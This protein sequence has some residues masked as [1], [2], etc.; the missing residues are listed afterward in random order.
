MSGGNWAALGV[1]AGLLALLALLLLLLCIPF[2]CAVCYI[3]AYLRDPPSEQQPLTVAAFWLDH[4]LSAV[5]GEV[6]GLSGVKRCC[7][8][9]EELQRTV[10]QCLTDF[11]LYETDNSGGTILAV[12]NDAFAVVKC[13]VAVQA[14]VRQLATAD[15]NE[16]APAA[17]PPMVSIGVATGLCRVEMVKEGYYHVAKFRGRCVMEAEQI[18][19]DAADGRIMASESTWY[20]LSELDGLQ[21]TTRLIRA[22]IGT[23]LWMVS[24]NMCS[25][26]LGQDV[27]VLESMNSRSDSKSVDMS[28]IIVK[29]PYHVVKHFFWKVPEE[30]RINLLR[31]IAES[32]GSPIPEQDSDM[33]DDKYCWMLIGFIMDGAA[34]DRSPSV[35]DSAEASF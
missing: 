23:L 16:D 15:S 19:T 29:N 4:R 7:A 22:P 2:C 20:A 24:K 10:E 8:E 35:G 18:A 21:V 12:S 9:R 13:C 33:T 34:D 26:S 11:G 31:A 3:P 27:Y 5:E 28:T 25:R 30:Q 14:A 6:E 1:A 17:P 32:C